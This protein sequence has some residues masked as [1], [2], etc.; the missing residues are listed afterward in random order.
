LYLLHFCSQLRSIRHK[1]T[2][3]Q[4]YVFVDFED[5]ATALAALERRLTLGG[6]ALAS[7]PVDYHAQQREREQLYHQ[8]PG[9]FLSLLLPVLLLFWCCLLVLGASTDGNQ[10]TGVYCFWAIWAAGDSACCSGATAGAGRAGA[11]HQPGQVGVAESQL[12]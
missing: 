10:C 8:R 12:L 2:A 1:P 4:P 3:E 9:M 7:F 6:Q 5:Q 11:G